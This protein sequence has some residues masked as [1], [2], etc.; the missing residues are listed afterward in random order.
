MKKMR[1]YIHGAKRS[2]DDR[3]QIND[4]DLHPGRHKYKKG[5]FLFELSNRLL[6]RADLKKLLPNFSEKA[7]Q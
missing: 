5:S 6:R 1:L 2:P 3:N 4:S 7:K